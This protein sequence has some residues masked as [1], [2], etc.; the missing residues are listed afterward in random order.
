MSQENLTIV[1]L[2]A[3]NVTNLKA[4]R[5]TPDINIVVLSGDN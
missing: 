3:N 2:T 4:V 1:Q 5:I